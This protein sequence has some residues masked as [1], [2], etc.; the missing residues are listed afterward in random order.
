VKAILS[1]LAFLV[2]VFLAPAIGAFSA[3]G[4]WYAGLTKPDW[5]PPGWLFGPVWTVLYVMIATAGWLV[6][7]QGGVQENRLVLA[8]FLLQLVLNAAWTPLFFGLH[9]MGIAF[10]EILCLWGAILAFILLAWPQHRAA[11]LLLV[12]Y[13][14]WVTFAAVLNFTLW[15]LNPS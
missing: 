14:G 15:R 6:W 5:N 7:R 4:E 9:A 10:A 1:Y 8:A 3:P 2:L 13:L 11:A 12:P